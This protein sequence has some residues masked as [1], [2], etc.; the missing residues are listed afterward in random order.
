MQLEKLVDQ[1]IKTEILII[2]SEAAGA[3]AAIEAQDAGAKDV[4]VVTKGLVGRSGNTLMA[5]KGIQ[6]AIGHGDPRDNPDVFFDDVVKGGDYLVN[7]KLSECLTRLSVTEPIKMEKWGA[8][9]IKKDGKFVQVQYPGSS[10]PRGLLPMGLNGGLQWRTAFKNQFK[11]LN[12]RLMEDILITNLL[13]KDGEVSGAFGVSLRDGKNIVFQA[14]NTILA[15]GG[16]TGIYIHTD[17]S[18]DNTGDGY[19]MAYRAGCELVDM[20]FQQFFPTTCYTPPFEHNV[21][22][23]ELRYFLHGRFYNQWGEQFMERYYPVEKDWALRD[24]TSRAIFLENKRG[25]GSP[26]GGAWL[27]LNHLPQGCIDEWLRVFKPPYINQLKKYEIDVFKNGVETGPACHYSMGGVRVN[28]DCESNIKRLYCVGEVAGGMDGAERI[29]GGPAITW[30][31]GMGLI[32]GQKTAKLAKEMDY[33]EVDV[34]QVSQEIKRLE[35]IW[36]SNNGVQGFQ[37]RNQIR[38][39]MWDVCSLVRDKEGLESGLKLVEK[40]KNEDLPRLGISGMTRTYNKSFVEAMEAHSQVT[41]AE[42]ILRAALMREESR[43]SHYRTDFLERDNK[44]WLKNI[45][46]KQGKG[47]INL[48]TTDPIMH[49]MLPKED[50]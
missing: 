19:A 30:C 22:V 25:M 11:R 26:H 27:G 45:V 33:P 21:F 7:Q 40:L 17:G 16:V 24:P 13:V 5:G 35:P 31:L 4:L 12:T 44:K 20:E 37:V 38:Q 6:A 29:D 46:I 42:M 8:Q 9:F 10:Y 1:V 2:G 34:E 41:C 47:K 49:R 18:L 14:K 43:K 32:A 39:M 3:K 28:E 36:N 23:A 50:L 15:T 48:T